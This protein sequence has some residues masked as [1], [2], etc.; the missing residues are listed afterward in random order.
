MFSSAA[1]S[2]SKF[3]IPEAEHSEE[4]SKGLGA[5]KSDASEV[6]MPL[7]I[8]PDRVSHEVNTNTTK[9]ANNYQQKKIRLYF[10][11]NDHYS[12]TGILG[13]LP[14]CHREGGRSE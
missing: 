1:N 9:H 13:R 10:L 11:F 12:T 2:T 8:I 7:Q 6:K 5:G 4:H 3:N 14:G